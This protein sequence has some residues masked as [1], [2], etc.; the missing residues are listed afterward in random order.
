[1]ETIS[2]LRE[3]IC[4]IEDALLF[5]EINDGKNEVERWTKR[6]MTELKKASS[7]WAFGE[8]LYRA[9]VAIFNNWTHSAGR[10]DINMVESWMVQYYG[11]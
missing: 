4:P 3:A 9:M 7:E 2:E 8:E 5:L 6:E 10:A 11:E 1:M